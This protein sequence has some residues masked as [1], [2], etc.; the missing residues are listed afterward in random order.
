MTITFKQFLEA[1]SLSDE[2][3]Q[4]IAEGLSDV[5][6]FGWLKGPDNKAKID[7]IKAERD[8]L[9][10]RRDRLAMQKAAEL[11]GWLDKATEKM[12]SLRDDDDQRGPYDRDREANKSGARMAKMPSMSG[13]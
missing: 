6:G 9:K 12:P 7:K 3:F 11:D 4:A 1:T 10:N 5:P 13:R 8:K 2:E